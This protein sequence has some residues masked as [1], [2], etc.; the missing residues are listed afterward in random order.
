MSKPPQID[1]KQLKGPDE[2]MKKGNSALTFFIQRRSPFLMV[3]SLGAAAIVL[4]YGLDYWNSRQLIAGWNAFHKAEKLDETKRWDEYK[5]VSEVYS[6]SRPGFVASTKVADH[7]FESAR[8]EFFLDKSK[9]KSAAIESAE[10][11][12]KA[13]KFS[14]LLPTEKQLLTVDYAEALELS[15]QIDSAIREYRVASELPGD[16]K[17]YALFKL[18]GA[19]ESKG[20]AVKAEESYQKV[21]VDFPNTEF[22]KMAKNGLR[23]MKSPTFSK[24]GS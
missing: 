19:L 1:R 23:R 4:F 7:L 17:P 12:A 24:S 8:K 2:F 5:K 15:D 14:D 16:V 22:A 10:W 20:E 9:A 13:R 21:T 11:Y 3:A 18:A 6:K